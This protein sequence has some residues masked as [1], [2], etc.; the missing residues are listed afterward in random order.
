MQNGREDRNYNKFLKWLAW[1]VPGIAGTAVERLDSEGNHIAVCSAVAD[2]LED[3]A[4]DILAVGTAAAGYSHTAAV[5]DIAE[6]VGNAG[7]AQTAGT[8][9]VV[10]DVDTVVIADAVVWTDATAE[11]TDT[12]EPA[13]IA[14]IAEVAEVAGTVETADIV[15]PADIAVGLAAPS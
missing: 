14:D 5:V 6:A 7:H 4:A 12:V 3:I 2:S 10:V 13:D 15:E 1:E 9:V 11:H 8:A